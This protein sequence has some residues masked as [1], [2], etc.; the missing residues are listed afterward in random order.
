MNKF[1]GHFNTVCEHKKQVFINCKKA[2]I[3][4]RGILHDLSKFSYVEFLEGV[5]YY[6]GDRS[7]INACKEQNGVSNAWLHHK[8]RNRHHFEYYWDMNDG[9]LVAHQMP[10]ID[11]LEMI[12]DILAANKVY[13]KEKFTY[14]KPYENWKNALVKLDPGLIHPQTR[15]FIL[16]ML[17]TVADE[18][19]DA[20][21]EQKRA[22]NLYRKAERIYKD[23][24]IHN[25]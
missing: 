14:K 19:S 20:C 2:G 11:V 18:N 6:Q 3:P 21:L 25:W 12:C 15:T 13:N 7:P 8:G 16:M 23:E 4:I 24:H 5:K 10:F 9:K 17:K 22:L 1:I